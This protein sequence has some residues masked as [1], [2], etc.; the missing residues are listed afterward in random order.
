MT[1]IRLVLALAALP[2]TPSD[3][4]ETLRRT[5]SWERTRRLSNHRP[6][7]RRLARGPARGRRRCSSPFGKPLHTAPGHGLG[8]L[9]FLFPPQAA[10]RRCSI[11]LHNRARRP[12]RRGCRRDRNQRQLHGHTRT[13]VPRPR[14]QPVALTNTADRTPRCFGTLL[15]PTLRRSVC[16]TR[17]VQTTNYGGSQ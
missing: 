9:R 1:P 10:P 11:R 13:G 7:V 4:R 6:T 15:L 16:Q 5:L 17:R 12:D 8:L 3:P 2:G 14:K